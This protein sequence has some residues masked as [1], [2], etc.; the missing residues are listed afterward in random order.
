MSRVIAAV[1]ALM[2]T[3]AVAAADDAHAGSLRIEDAWSRATPAG[4]RVGVGYLRIV[5]DGEHADRLIGASS[6]AAGRVMVHRTVEADGTTRMEHQSDGV[7]IPAGARVTLEP[8]GYHLMLMQLEQPLGKGDRVP[9]TL[10]FEHAGPIEV[11]LA[12]RGMTEG[13]E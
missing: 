9:V 1:A 2:L 13:L 5:N 10:T 6:S 11:E 7:A 12:V 8:G 3:A 4:S